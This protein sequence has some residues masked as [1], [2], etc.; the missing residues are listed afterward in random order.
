MGRIPAGI[1][2][3]A[4]LLLTV[5]ADARSANPQAVYTNKTEFAI[6]FHSNPA[7]IQRLGARE[8][9]LL[10]SVDNGQN[11]QHVQ[12]VQPRATRFMVRA[13]ADG[14]YWFSVRTV[15]R[16]NQLHPTGAITPE[17]KVVVDT[18]SPTLQINVTQPNPGQIM[19]NWT[20]AD[21]NLDLSSLV[22]ES[23]KAGETTWSRVYVSKNRSGKTSWNV[24]EG[25]MIRVRGRII[26]KSGNAATAEEGIRL[27]PSKESVPKPRVPN[28]NDPIAGKGAIQNSNLPDQFPQH[29]RPVSQHSTIGRGGAPRKFRTANQDNSN[30][31]NTGSST[32]PRFGP[33]IVPNGGV[34]TPPPP[35]AQKAVPRKYQKFPGN[36]QSEEPLTREIPTKIVNRTHFRLGYT[37]DKVGKSG[38][39]SV[40]LY[41]TQDDGEKWYFY[42]TD[43]DQSS[44]FDVAVPKDGV[45]G[46]AIRVRSGV[47]LTEPLPQPGDKPAI[48]V[49]VD[50]TAPEVALLPILQ[51]QGTD[52]NKFLIRWKAGDEKLHA[53][54]VAIAYSASADGPWTTITDWTVDSGSHLWTASK[55][56]PARIYIR[57]AVRDAAGNTGFAQTPRPIIVD[58]V[59]PSARITDVESDS[60]RR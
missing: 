35:T 4:W 31:S 59:K 27:S 16:N 48:N 28:F 49:V 43:K 44:P 40:E 8:L 24:P 1:L 20:A 51:G 29:Q 46:F 23:Q 22:M 52:S 30:T 55:D 56:V 45:Y 58:S 32:G 9:H 3:A 50:Q 21:A 54:P 6:P 34:D 33:S 37:I 53:K 60:Q 19:L 10:V 5:P 38:L 41:I 25:G 26:D 11:W 7:E 13:P 57:V 18:K 2:T 36:Q 47:G 15:D 42:G 39:Q 17:L 12:T 14:E